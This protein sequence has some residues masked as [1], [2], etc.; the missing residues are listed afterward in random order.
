[1]AALQVPMAELEG[2]LREVRDELAA[3]W[4]PKDKVGVRLIATI[5]HGLRFPTW[6][7]LSQENKDDFALADLVRGWVAC[8]L[9]QN[10][11]TSDSRDWGIRRSPLASDPQMSSGGGEVGDI[12]TADR[13]K[14][15]GNAASYFVGAIR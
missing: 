10:E 1:V 14:I 13:V 9:Q 8:I 11:V 4:E 15:R 7:S 6:Q 3:G 2:F 5:G 12:V